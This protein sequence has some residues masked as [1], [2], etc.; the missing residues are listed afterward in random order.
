[1]TSCMTK[2]TYQFIPK[3]LFCLV[4]AKKGFGGYPQVFYS[5]DCEPLTGE[6]SSI[7][8]KISTYVACVVKIAFIQLSFVL[9][10]TY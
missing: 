7:K 6:V 5:T 1:M 3:P 2:A 10:N 9:I 4:V 8:V